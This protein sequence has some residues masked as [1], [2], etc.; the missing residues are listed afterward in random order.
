M[1]DSENDNVVTFEN[2]NKALKMDNKE[3]NYISL[4]LLKIVSNEVVPDKYLFFRI[5]RQKELEGAL[6]REKSTFMGKEI[7]DKEQQEKYELE[8]C[9]YI[10]IDVDEGIVIELYGQFAPG[11]KGFFSIIN[12][13]LCKSYSSDNILISSNKILTDKM[14]ETYK[15][16][17]VSLNEISYKYNIPDASRLLELGLDPKQIKALKELDM[18]QIK[19]LIKNKPHVPLTKVSAKIGYV[20]NAFQECTKDIKDTLKFKGNITGGSAAQ[21]YKFDKDEVTYTI[22]LSSYKQE[23]SQKIKLSLEEMAEQAYNKI[24]DIYEKNKENIKTYILQE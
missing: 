12:T 16:G 4:E 17:G 3:E 10:L 19:I 15:K 2:G 24:K 23:D 1:F 21:E 20:I 9:T 8:I 6:K 11:A 22:N 7:L 14:I 18:F 13:Y 5:G